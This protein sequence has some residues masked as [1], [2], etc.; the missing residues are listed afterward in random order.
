MFSLI[1]A[2]SLSAVPAQER[3]PPEFR[4]DVRVI[5]LDVSA[6]D[7]AGR[8]V[9]GLT[10][11]DFVVLEDGRPVDVTF[12]EAVDAA[13]EAPE[14]PVQ[15]PS[16]EAPPTRRI[17]LLV[18]T[19]SMGAGQVRRSR[20]A[21]LR[22]LRAA[23]APGDWVRL[24]NLGTGEIFDGHVPGDRSRLEAAAR[25]LGHRP[26]LLAATEI[27]QPIRERVESRSG[28]DGPST[29]ESLGSALSIYARTGG[30]L[31]TLE[32]TLVELHAVRGR[33]ALV[34]ISP[35]FP[36][37]R[38]LD[39][40]LERVASLA[41]E[42]ATAVYFVDVMGLDGLLPEGTGPGRL[43]P[44]FEEAWQRGGGAQDLA[45]AT[46]GFT[47]RFSN[48]LLPAL[49]RV[50]AEMRTYYVLGYVPARPDDGRF[51]SIKVKVKVPGVQVRTKK[52]Y[53]AGARRR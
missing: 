12:F 52:G 15:E 41:R 29:A 13:H 32:A 10:P 53:L 48:S 45:A 34:L 28:G 50:A 4:A 6:V 24:L 35:G 8:P 51:R 36:S 26:S 38:N 44:A 40:R 47:S 25:T 11:S 14:A 30:L 2:A 1:V 21:A 5:R 7:G 37:L 42:A 43:R 39:R 46:G 9:A 22:F 31:G 33:K 27:E 19:G 17:L 49:A 3:Q 23:T 20:D 18:D 16:S